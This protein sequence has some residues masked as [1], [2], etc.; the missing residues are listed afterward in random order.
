MVLWC[1]NCFSKKGVIHMAYFLKQSNLKKGTYLQIYES[2]YDPQRRDTAHRSHKAIG[3]V[4]E[5]IEKGIDDPISFFKEE[6]AKL[7]QQLASS[8]C[9]DKARH[10]S[11]ETPEKLLGYFPLKCIND[12]L[13]VGNYIKLMQT[14]TGL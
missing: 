8:R 5:L 3:Y 9:I 12:S 4:H 10:I 7:N 2:F 13:G 1:Y 11:E 6:T 14:V